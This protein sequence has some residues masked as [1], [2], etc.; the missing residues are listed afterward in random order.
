MVRSLINADQHAA[1]VQKR[2]KYPRSAVKELSFGRSSS[3]MSGIPD[4]LAF[5]VRTALRYNRTI[6]QSGYGRCLGPLLVL[7]PS[8][9]QRTRREG[10]SALY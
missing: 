5:A 4:S 10:H 6:V 9:S 8:V 1:L 2:G 3:S 7:P